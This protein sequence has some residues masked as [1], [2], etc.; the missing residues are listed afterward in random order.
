MFGQVAVGTLVTDVLAS[1]GVRAD[2]MIG[3]SLGESA[4]LFG[5]RAWSDRDEMYRRIEESTLFDSDLAPP[6][7]A[8]RRAYWLPPG[9]RSTG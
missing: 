7:D 1:L 8:A 5:V 6:Y 2:A 3:L 9:S 4:G